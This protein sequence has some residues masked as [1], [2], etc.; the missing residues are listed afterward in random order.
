M[1]PSIHPKINAAI[2]SKPES[3]YPI[4]LAIMYV[5]NVNMNAKNAPDNITSGLAIV[6]P[7]RSLVLSIAFMWV[8]LLNRRLPIG[9]SSWTC[10]RVLA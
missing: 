7:N 10:R 6:S 2:V 5:S 8:I 4:V 9:N 3:A 1:I